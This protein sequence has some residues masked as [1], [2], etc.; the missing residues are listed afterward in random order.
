MF[1]K[2][3]NANLHRLALSFL[4]R[5]FVA[6]NVKR[7]SLIAQEKYHQQSKDPASQ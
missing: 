3:K 7:M 6:K 5:N 1:R 4:P 2:N